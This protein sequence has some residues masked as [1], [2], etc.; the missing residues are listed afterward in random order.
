MSE[1][2]IPRE[3]QAGEYKFGELN[4]SDECLVFNYDEKYE[5]LTYEAPVIES[6]VRV[7]TVPREKMPAE[8]T[9][10]YD[11]DR[12]LEK[13]I[14]SNAGEPERLLYMWFRNIMK[15]E[16]AVLKYV[17]AQADEIAK[18][19]IKKKRTLSRLFF[20]R[21]YDGEAVELAVVPAT[22]EEAQAVIA[23]NDGDISAADNSGNY[24]REN[25]LAVVNEPLAV[26]LMCTYGEFRSMLFNKA[27]L[28]FEERVKDRVLEKISKTEDFQIISE[29]YD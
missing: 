14:F 20:G 25:M 10:V 29:E 16:H 24:P 23:E 19:I 27:A 11:K 13:I 3:F 12:A 28:T 22:A 21:F 17:K 7:Y 18:K 2:K 8:L 26:M 6:E 15:S 5:L 9:A 1:Y 4:G